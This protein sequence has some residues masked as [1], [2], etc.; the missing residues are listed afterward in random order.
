MT[1]HIKWF[2]N[3][4]V[5]LV[6]DRGKKILIDPLLTGNPYCPV[7]LE[8]FRKADVVCVTHGHLG[9]FGNAPEIVNQTGAFFVAP[10]EVCAHANYRR[11][12]SESLL[13][14]MEIGETKQLN[15][16][17]IIRVEGPHAP[18][19]EFEIVEKSYLKLG[20]NGGFLVVTEEKT[21]F[22]HSGDCLP[23]PKY[24]EIRERFHPAVAIVEL[25]KDHTGALEITK[26]V[27]PRKVIPFYRFDPSLAQ[28]KA[29]KSE[30]ER[31]QLSVEVPILKPGEGFSVS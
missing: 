10:R 2:G 9:H 23:T 19:P 15:G 18:G 5:E 7:K 6:T 25:K 8:D 12:V 26:L 16:V 30:V 13:V 28:P 21:A 17:E 14:P 20:T 29:F 11:G 27:Q 22:F 1:S 24:S 31:M 3:A 4:F